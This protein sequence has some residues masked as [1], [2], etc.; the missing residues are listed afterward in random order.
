MKLARLGSLVSDLCT[1][2][3]ASNRELIEMCKR[4]GEVSG[5]VHLAHTN[6]GD[7]LIEGGR[8]A[9]GSVARPEFPPRFIHLRRRSEKLGQ[10]DRVIAWSTPAAAMA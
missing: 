7:G 2:T 5:E 9:P 3:Y 6:E 4:S 10:M 1:D 8:G